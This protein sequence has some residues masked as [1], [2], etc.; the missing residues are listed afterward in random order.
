MKVFI[1][2]IL[3]LCLSC[4]CILSVS[5]CRNNEKTSSCSHSYTS[6]ITK[7]ATC[8][9]KGSKTY[10]CS[11]CG[12]SYDEEIT[13]TGNH[14]FTEKVTKEASCKEEG[15]KTHTCFICSN[16]Y[17]ESIDKTDDHEYKKTVSKNATDTVAG[18]RKYTCSICH[19]MYTEDFLLSKVTCSTVIASAHVKNGL[20]EV[21]YVYC[22]LESVTLNQE[23]ELIG[24]RVK[25]E[26]STT[27]KDF[28]YRTLFGIGIKKL[29][30]SSATY[31]IKFKMPYMSGGYGST[32]HVDFTVS[33]PKP[34]TEGISYVAYAYTVS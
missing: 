20:G 4:C 5:A 10:T 17:N 24:F 27:V 18:E 28:N 21:G 14:S 22:A 3:S 34:L 30:A 25:L 31:T 19:D 15:I 7:K 23:N 9:E 8:G 2:R 13:P 26:S 33:T 29:G 6:E 16:S 12:D 11:L 1:K 32:E